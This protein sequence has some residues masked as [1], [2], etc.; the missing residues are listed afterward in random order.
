MKRSILG[1]HFDIVGY[2]MLNSMAIYDDYDRFT[3][4]AVDKVWTGGVPKI[5]PLVWR[6]R[7]G[8]MAHYDVFWVSMFSIEWRA[9]ELE[10]DR[11]SEVK[12]KPAK[13]AIYS[14]IKFLFFGGVTVPY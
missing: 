14:S 7:F 2:V 3:F 9:K 12:W 11:N 10:K 13:V 5:Y 1:K 4:F 6:E 8:A